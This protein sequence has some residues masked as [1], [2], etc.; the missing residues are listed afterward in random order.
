MGRKQMASSRSA[1]AALVAAAAACA[2]GALLTPV[3]AAII[4]G[5]LFLAGLAAFSF[6][7]AEHVLDAIIKEELSPL[8]D[9]WPKKTA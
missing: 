3:F 7:R 4:A 2:T 8:R 6:H 5:V 9:K 1:G